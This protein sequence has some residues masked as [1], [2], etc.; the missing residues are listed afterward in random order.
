MK[1]NI[2]KAE[3]ILQLPS[4]NENSTFSTAPTT[5][6]V[7]LFNIFIY[8]KA[9]RKD[10]KKVVILTALSTAYALIKE[11]AKRVSCYETRAT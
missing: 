8:K 3:K 7:Y 4:K 6:T 11:N 9:G 2:R 1:F 5:T 10:G